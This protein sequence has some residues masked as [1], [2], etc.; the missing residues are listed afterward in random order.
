MFKF[1]NNI[2]AAFNLSSNLCSR[3]PWTFNECKNLTRVVNKFYICWRVNRWDFN[4]FFRF[5]YRYGKYR[6]SQHHPLI[7]PEL[8]IIWDHFHW[9]AGRRRRKKDS[10]L[11]APNF[12]HAAVGWILTLAPIISTS[13]SYL[14]LGI[15][16]LSCCNFQILVENH[17]CNGC[18]DSR[19]LITDRKKGKKCELRWKNAI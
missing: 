11:V 13:L 2:T 18:S 4:F 19:S 15:L 14:D 1:H 17:W 5:Q 16:Q 10:L 3:R 12:S 8:F 7:Q 9:E 6:Y